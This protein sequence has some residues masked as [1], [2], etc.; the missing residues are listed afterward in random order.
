[1]GSGYEIS[2]QE[3]LKVATALD[4]L[5]SDFRGC[6]RDAGSVRVPSVAYGQ[7]GTAAA[8]SSA[9]AQQQLITTLQALATVL[10][11]INERV[12]ASADGYAD[13]DRRIAA[14]LAQLAAEQVP[15]RRLSGGR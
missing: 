14:V 15:V 8:G 1:M 2:V 9:A 6:T 5:L 12:R 11:K 4:G 10:Q 13:R 3:V 7:V